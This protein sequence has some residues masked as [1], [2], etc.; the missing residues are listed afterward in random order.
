M[1][2]RCAPPGCT[3]HDSVEASASSTRLAYANGDADG[4]SGGST[5]RHD[6]RCLLAGTCLTMFY[7]P[8]GQCTWI[9]VSESLGLPRLY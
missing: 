6:V 4:G 8:A 1:V 7:L 9:P 5:G 3:Q 2:C